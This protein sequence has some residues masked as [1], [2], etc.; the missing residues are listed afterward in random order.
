MAA[1]KQCRKGKK[2][3]VKHSKLFRQWSGNVVVSYHIIQLRTA[4]K[5]H[6][7][8]SRRFSLF[9]VIYVYPPADG[10]TYSLSSPHFRVFSRMLSVN[11][12]QLHSPSSASCGIPA[13]RSKI[14]SK[15]IFASC[16]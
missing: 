3:R 10:D 1:A 8:V 7:A 4:V 15:F 12:T 9:I 16:V 11:L 2:L 13:V 14:L 6:P 5:V